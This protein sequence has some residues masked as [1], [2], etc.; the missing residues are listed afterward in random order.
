MTGEY[1]GNGDNGRDF[2]PLVIFVL[3][4]W[5]IVMFL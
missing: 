3:V 2:W 5:L 4:V 1:D